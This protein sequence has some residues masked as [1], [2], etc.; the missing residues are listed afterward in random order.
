[1]EMMLTPTTRTAAE[2]LV[3]VH[4][5]APPFADELRAVVAGIRPLVGSRFSCAVVPRW[6]GKEFTD[7]LP[8]LLS[9]LR[10]AL[11]RAGILR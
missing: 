3:V 7:E 1:M 10:D 2:M 5:V 6:H 4:D 8:R 9:V 11:P